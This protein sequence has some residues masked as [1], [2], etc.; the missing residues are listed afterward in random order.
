MGELIHLYTQDT[1]Y[2]DAQG[3]PELSTTIS[4]Q[5]RDYTRSNLVA[6]TNAAQPCILSTREFDIEV[7]TVKVEK[8]IDTTGAGDSFLGSYVGNFSLDRHIT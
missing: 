1:I 7:P 5:L 2:P 3:L 8:V 4:K 6:I